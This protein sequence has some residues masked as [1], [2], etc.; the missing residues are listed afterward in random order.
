MLTY[1]STQK[2]MLLDC[3]MCVSRWLTVS[4]SNHMVGTRLLH[5]VFERGCVHVDS[6]Y[7]KR[8]S[9]KMLTQHCLQFE[10]SSRSLTLCASASYSIVCLSACDW[11]NR[12]VSWSL[13]AR[14][15]WRMAG[16]ECWLRGGSELQLFRVS[17]IGVI[18]CAKSLSHD[19]CIAHSCGSSSNWTCG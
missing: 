10:S 16:E 15:Q 9:E 4:K 17:N 1:S 5:F 11:E 7:I 19:I 8:W 18:V 2:K 12:R 6:C 14:W 3:L 13:P